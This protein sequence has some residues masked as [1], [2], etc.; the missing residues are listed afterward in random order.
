[1]PTVAGDPRRTQLC[2]RMHAP[3]AVPILRGPELCLLA[4]KGSATQY[5]LVLHHASSPATISTSNHIGQAISN[6]RHRNNFK[7]RHY[8]LLGMQRVF[9][10]VPARLPRAAQVRGVHWATCKA[11]CL[12]RAVDPCSRY[13]LTLKAG[14]LAE[15]LLDYDSPASS[16]SPQTHCIVPRLSDLNSCVIEDPVGY[17]DHDSCHYGSAVFLL[18]LAYQG[19]PRPCR[20]KE[21]P[22]L[23]LCSFPMACLCQLSTW[24]CT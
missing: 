20:T 9:G 24:E 17:L 21:R 11:F 14:R 19:T 12:L 5:S 1:V 18:S 8:V 10:P 13:S 15:Q 4:Q 2:S 6:A 22:K 23:I 16:A 7:P 3:P